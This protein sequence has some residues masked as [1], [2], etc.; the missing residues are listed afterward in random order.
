[1]THRFQGFEIDEATREL[2]AA[3]RVLTLQPRVFDLLVCLA[4]NRDR[5]VPKEELLEAVWPG[6][7][8]ADGSLQRAISLARSALTEAGAPEAIRTYSRRGYRFCVDGSFPPETGDRGVVS[9]LTPLESARLAYAGSD[10]DGVIDAMGQVSDLDDATPQDWQA[11][12]HAVQ[13]SGRPKET[14][15]PL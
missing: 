6:V 4:K 1:M 13:C 11:W 3:G 2:R 9:G 10:W 5:V 7:I 8:V 14:V 15:L 12:V